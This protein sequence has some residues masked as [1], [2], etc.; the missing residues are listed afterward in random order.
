M[1]TTFKN[2]VLFGALGAVF[3]VSLGSFATEA[4][5]SF[6]WNNENWFT[7]AHPKVASFTVH[8]DGSAYGLTDTGISFYQRTID[9]EFGIRIQRFEMQDHYHYIVEGEAVYSLEELSVRLA[10][11]HERLTA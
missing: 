1:L 5:E 7:E 10:E 9:N 11:E 2:V 8:P 6:R 4:K 3:F